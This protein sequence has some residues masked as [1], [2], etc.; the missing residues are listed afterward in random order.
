MQSRIELG[1]FAGLRLSAANSAIIGFMVIWAA[2][3]VVALTALELSSIEAMVGGLICAVIHFALE[4]AHQLGHAIAARATGWPMSGVH[5]W[6]VLAMSKYPSDEPEL[7][8]RVHIRRA[9][10]GPVASLLL[11]IPLGLLAGAL[12]PW[13]ATPGWI[14]AFAF[15]DCLLFF[16]IGALL[17]L[18]FTDGS[19][20]LQWWG[21]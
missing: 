2:A 20:V 6:L 5:F 8:G 1:R 4:F 17:P 15:L 13:D 16:G 9:L 21:K 7:P 11:S 19:T 14:A 3:F 18:G 12:G 10:G